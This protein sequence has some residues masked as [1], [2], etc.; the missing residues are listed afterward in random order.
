MAVEFPKCE[1]H[2]NRLPFLGCLL[3]LDTASDGTVLG[4]EVPGPYDPAKKKHRVVV[5]RSV[6]AA[7]LPTLLGMG[8]NY[9]PGFGGH[10]RRHKVGIITEAHI[11]MRRLMVSG[12]IFGRDYP[13]VQACTDPL[14]MSYELHDAHIENFDAEVWRVTKATFVGAAILQES[15]AAH[16]AT[17]FSMAPLRGSK[18]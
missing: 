3:L 6:A 12:Y 13:E 7:A 17:F 8:V 2:P 10:D 1:G 15:K 9:S 16:R 14:G 18:R 4:A 11:E 5:P